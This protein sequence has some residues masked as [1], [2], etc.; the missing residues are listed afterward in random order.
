[1]ATT[2][3]VMMVPQGECDTV[4]EAKVKMDFGVIKETSMDNENV[5]MTSIGQQTP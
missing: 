1:M 3:M 2:L 5:L 4:E